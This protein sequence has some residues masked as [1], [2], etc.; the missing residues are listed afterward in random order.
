MNKTTK[1]AARSAI[2]S[3]LTHPRGIEVNLCA[4][5]LALLADENV[6]VRKAVEVLHVVQHVL[7]QSQQQRRVVIVR[8]FRQFRDHILLRVRIEWW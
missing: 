2:I 4:Q 5:N 8:L 6:V 7:P 3:S 1:P